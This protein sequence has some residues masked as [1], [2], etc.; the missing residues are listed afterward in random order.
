M[1]AY[2]LTMLLGLFGVKMA[3]LSGGPIGIGIGCITALVA[4]A[5]MLLDFDAIKQ[6]EYSQAPRWMEWYGGFMVLVSLLWLYMEL[7]R[8]GAMIAGNRED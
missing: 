5:S 4:A 2:G 7:L 3:F 8:L 1:I 6:M